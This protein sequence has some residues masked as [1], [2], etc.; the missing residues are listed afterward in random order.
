MAM[1]FNIPIF[2]YEYTIEEIEAITQYVNE[3]HGLV[4]TGYSFGGNNDLLLPLVGINDNINMDISYAENDYDDIYYIIADNHPLF[5]DLSNPFNILNSLNN[6]PTEDGSWDEKYLS[7]A[8]FIAKSFEGERADG[9]IILN[10][11]NNVYLSMT[12]ADYSDDVSN[13]LMYNS[14]LYVGNPS[15]LYVIASIPNAG[16]I[17]ETLKFKGFASGGVLPYNWSWSFGD[18]NVSY[19]QNTNNTYVTVGDYT[20]NLA[21]TDSSDNVRCYSED[22][23]IDVFGVDIHGSSYGLV[24]NFVH[25]T[26]VTHGGFPPYNWSWEFDDGY[27]SGAQNVTRMFDTPGIYNLTLTVT[28]SR[29]N[30]KNKTTIVTVNEDLMIYAPGPYTAF[31]DELVQFHGVA[32]GGF[33]PYVLFCWDFGDGSYE[34]GKTV[35][36]RYSLEGVYNVTLT[37]TDSAGFSAN[38]STNAIISIVFV[39]AGG[40]YF[41]RINESIKFQQNKT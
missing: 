7:T 3:G 29:N 17:N 22:I 15:F 30:T 23:S 39:D 6:P 24:G 11:N 18:G 1:P 41:G 12:L 19:D 2:N 25:F 9:A 38:D 28:D 21:V 37:V 27:T 8:T 4:I 26:G 14:L 5:N 33:K 34:Y 20:V 40:A 35:F 32:D 31:P 16:F 36:H 13:Q 10:E